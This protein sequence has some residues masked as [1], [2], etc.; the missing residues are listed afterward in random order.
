MDAVCQLATTKEDPDGFIDRFPSRHYNLLEA[1]RQCKTI[2]RWI[3]AGGDAAMGIYYY[4][5]PGPINEAMPHRAYPGFTRLVKSSK[6]DGPQY[7]IQYGLPYVCLR[8]SWI[9]HDEMIF[10]ERF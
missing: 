3:L 4:P 1:A 9:M 2:R 8:A 5:Q 10:S 7:H 6:K